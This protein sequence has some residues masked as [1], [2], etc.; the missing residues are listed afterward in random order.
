MKIT[1]LFASAVGVA[2]ASTISAGCSG[3]AGSATFA[4]PS[5][6]TVSGHRAAG[7]SASRLLAMTTLAK[8]TP[9]REA[10]RFG[11]HAMPN[12]PCSPWPICMY[13]AYADVC[14]EC[15]DPELTLSDSIDNFV[16]EYASTLI[17]LQGFNEPYGECVDAKGDTW[18]T[19]FVGE[20]VAE[21]ARGGTQPIS[22]LSTNG[23][24][25]GCSVSPNGDLAVANFSAASGIGNID[26]F[27]HDSGTPTAYSNEQDLYLWPPGYDNKGNL[28]VETQTYGGAVGVAEIP[29]GGASLEPV[30][31]NQTIYFPGSVMWDGKY[32]TLTDQDA[33]G[34]PSSPATTIYQMREKGMANLIVAGSTSLE[35]NCNG[36]QVDVVQPFIAGRK[37]TPVNKTQGQVLIG[38]NLSC[39]NRVDAWQ[40]PAGGQP[41][42]VASPVPSY[43]YG[44]AVSVGKK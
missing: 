11:T 23:Y 20:S 9:S 13:F 15:P 3:N 36:S 25:V 32:I 34:N 4:P 38:G 17:T 19:N 22:T 27:K 28:F 6:P 40:Y 29:A 31:V 24:S 14:G 21:Y 2:L 26:V 39:E 10:E 30:S 41:I 12:L 35:D 33:G 7:A 16:D 8:I 43:A 44:Q 18:I 1:S 5:S 37:N 42:A